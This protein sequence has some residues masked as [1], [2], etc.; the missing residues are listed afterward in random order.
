M[1]VRPRGVRWSVRG[2]LR[3]R[4]RGGDL[5]LVVE[6]D[7]KVDGLCLAS[8]RA[9]ATTVR[10]F[11]RKDQNPEPFIERVTG[12][13]GAPVAT[14]PRPDRVTLLWQ[15]AV[16][17]Y[18]DSLYDLKKPEE[19]TNRPATRKDYKSK[20][21]VPELQTFRGRAI[22]TITREEIAEANAK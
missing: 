8:A 5:G 20:L 14:G 18:L 10:E 11:A 22:S 9:W 21:A 4:K 19:A 3:G 6:G 17:Q 13:S 2:G 16:E 1:R 15:D 7:D 12:R